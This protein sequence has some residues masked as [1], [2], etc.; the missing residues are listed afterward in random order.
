MSNTQKKFFYYYFLFIIFLF[1]IILFIIL[2]VTCVKTIK[3]ELKYPI[4]TFKCLFINIINNLDKKSTLV[5]TARHFFKFFKLRH[6]YFC[7]YQ[8]FNIK[9]YKNCFSP[10]IKHHLH[11]NSI[12]F[13]LDSTY[14]SPRYNK[15][16]WSDR[17]CTTL[18]YIYIKVMLICNIPLFL[19][20][21]LNSLLIHCALVYF[22]F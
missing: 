7:R 4:L 18:P 20:L 6:I 11:Y 15:K 10:F 8:L 21:I 16:T 9:F 22:V 12:I 13:N 3:F 14:S 1:I 19:F 5:G 2:H 17:Y